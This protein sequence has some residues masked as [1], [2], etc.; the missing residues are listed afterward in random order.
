MKFI[1]TPEEYSGFLNSV[2]IQGGAEDMTRYV[3][4]V[5]EAV[6]AAKGSLNS[7]CL[8]EFEAVINTALAMIIALKAVEGDG[9]EAVRFRHCYIA[10]DIALILVHHWMLD[11]GFE[12]HGDDDDED[13]PVHLHSS[14][15][16]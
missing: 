5:L 2:K 16:H 3:N 7:D 1:S 9:T 14:A 12:S 4:L 8:D 13:A 6:A 11:H 15:V 10:A